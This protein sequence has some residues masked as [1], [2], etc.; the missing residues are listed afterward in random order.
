MPFRFLLGLMLAAVVLGL[1]PEAAPAQTRYSSIG[2]GAQMGAP[3]GVTLRLY[4]RAP[5][6]YDFL[7]AWDL[8]DSFFLNVHGLRERP[9]RDSQL[10]FYYGPGGLFGIE[11]RGN[12]L[13]VVLGASAN[14]GL[15]YFVERFEV[16][17]QLTPRLILL[18][19]TTADLGGGVGLRYYL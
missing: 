4:E 2:F 16:F 17:L 8:D 11:R 5:Y 13:D 10:N 3:T 12:D 14:V 18:E 19:R 7:A 9:I 6:I 15:N 1:R